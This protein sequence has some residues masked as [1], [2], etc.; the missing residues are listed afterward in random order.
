[1]ALINSKLK[2]FSKCLKHKLQ[3]FKI[4]NNKIFVTN[5]YEIVTRKGGNKKFDITKTFKTSLSHF[6][7]ISQTSRIFAYFI[8]LEIK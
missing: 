3:T 2:Y 7:V 1:M 5:V 6:E 8:K 4:S